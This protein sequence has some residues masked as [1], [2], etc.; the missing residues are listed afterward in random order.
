MYRSR[1]HLGVRWILSVRLAR[2]DEELEGRDVTQ[3]GNQGLQLIRRRDECLHP[4]IAGDMGNLVWNQ[5]GV[6]RHVHATRLRGRKNREDLFHGGIK[7][8]P[9]TIATLHTCGAK[10]TRNR[11]TTI[12]D[13][14]ICQASR[15]VDKR[16]FVWMP[17]STVPQ[18]MVDQEIHGIFSP[19]LH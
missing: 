17:S 1:I 3:R 19:A 14:A 4:A 13:L 10:S 6:N 9:D 2:K 18:H 12:G 16:L 8:D 11:R 7:V 15:S 5:D